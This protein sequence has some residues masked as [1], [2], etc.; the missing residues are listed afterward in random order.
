MINPRYFVKIEIAVYEDN[1]DLTD[2]FRTN[3]KASSHDLELALAYAS[4]V[5]M[6]VTEMALTVSKKHA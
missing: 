1:D 2:V 6:Y 4:K 5:N 3:I